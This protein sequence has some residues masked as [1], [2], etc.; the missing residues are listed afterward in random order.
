VDRA[1]CLDGV[2][3]EIEHVIEFVLK[4]VKA[5]GVVLNVPGNFLLGLFD[6]VGIAVQKHL[7]VLGVNVE[8]IS[9]DLD[10]FFLLV[11]LLEELVEVLSKSLNLFANALLLLFSEFQTVVLFSSKLGL[12]DGVN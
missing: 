7:E 6:L 8:I 12:L 3:L 10:Y 9:A 2:F 1:H 4:L 11:I 5:D